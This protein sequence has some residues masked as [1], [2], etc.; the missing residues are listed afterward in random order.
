MKKQMTHERLKEYTNLRCEIAMFEDQIA[1]SEYQAVSD[2]VEMSSQTVPYSK[3]VIAVRGYMD[4]SKPRIVRKKEI[5]ER[6][7]AA[8]EH[9]IEAVADSLLRQLLTRRYIEGRT[10]KESASII[11]YSDKQAKRILDT[12]FEKLSTN[13]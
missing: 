11:G 7:C 4:K 13:V 2:T 6:E 5:K 8:I 1:N 10:L 9:F 3:H 12:F